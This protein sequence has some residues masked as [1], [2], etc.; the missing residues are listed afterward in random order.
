MRN[1][2][3]NPFFCFLLIF[4]VQSCLI[5]PIPIQTLY[6]RYVGFDKGD[7]P[8]LKD[9]IVKLNQ[10]N[11]YIV[12]A[13]EALIPV[14][15]DSLTDLSVLHPLHQYVHRLE[16]YD[17]NEELEKGSVII[18]IE[19]ASSTVKNTPSFIF[20]RYEIDEN[21]ELKLLFNFGEH[22]MV[23]V[24]NDMIFKKAEYLAE[25]FAQASFK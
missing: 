8:V 9:E 2:L 11:D 12:T 21:G 16:L 19:S 15:R 17:Q 14:K 13:D 1:L 7:L 4:S 6:Y 20:R 25:K 18:E 24:K 10:Q 22:P 3:L 23:G 5:E